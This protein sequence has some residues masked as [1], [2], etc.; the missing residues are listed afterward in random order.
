MRNKGFFIAVDGCDA[1]GKSSA[2]ELMKQFFIKERGIKEDNIILT[3]EP[4]GTYVGEEIRSLLLDPD[5]RKDKMDMKTETMLMF[6][7]RNQLIKELIEPSLKDGKIV[8]SD[9]WESSTYT[10]QLAR[11][12]DIKDIDAMSQFV[13]GDF[14]P[15]MMMILDV[16]PEKTLERIADKRGGVMDRTESNDKNYFKTIR[17]TYLKYAKE[18]DAIV[19]DANVHLDDMLFSIYQKLDENTLHMKK[20]EC[21]ISIRP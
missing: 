19:I 4:G 14:K 8:I 15:D 17:E 13:C 2:M 11:G 3:R 6:A 21:N 10:Y 16:S 18:K 20:K 1:A 5:S 7:S 9:R 12:A